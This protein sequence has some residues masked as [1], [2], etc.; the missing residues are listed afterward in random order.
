MNRETAISRNVEYRAIDPPEGGKPG[1][2][3]GPVAART[4]ILEIEVLRA[5]AIL[6]V[7]TAHS[8]NGLWWRPTPFE[9][10]LSFA[11][12]VDLFFCVSGFVIAR[13]FYGPLSEAA[14]TGGPVYWN[15]VAAF[16]IRRAYRI[17]PLAWLWLAIPLLMSV[18]FNR[19]GYS[20]HFL[21]N[22]G[23]S[24][25]AVLNVYN[26]HAAHC[27]EQSTRWCGPDTIYWSLSLEE[28]FYLLFP[29]LMLLP[30]RIMIALLLAA[31]VWMM[32]RTMTT[33]AFMTRIDAICLGV[34]IAF[35]KQSSAYNSF[36]P[37]FLSHPIKRATVAAILIAALAIVPAPGALVP[38]YT[39]MVT[40]ICGALVLIA[41]YDRGFLMKPGLLRTALVWIGGRSFALYL[42]HN[43]V[44][45]FVHELFDRIFPDQVPTDTVKV[46]I[47][48]LQ[49]TLMLSISDLSFRYFETPLRRRGS[50]IAKAWMNRSGEP[51][52]PA[53]APTA[54]A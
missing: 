35:F 31:I 2:L 5:V 37:V 49:L 50:R 41:S 21:G 18:F 38:A 8:H 51:A 47:I 43:P 17:I 36:T 19:S 7:I 14:A 6:F 46:A 53:T 25:S 52:V 44:A 23:D 28:Q 13:S 48:L 54:G 39:T 20:S 11:Y 24:V 3:A 10:S 15:A 45:W 26:F 16:W 42:I 4:K 33:L 9:N 40:A 12:G 22:A 1:P 27:V 29:L 30:K 32:T 34:L